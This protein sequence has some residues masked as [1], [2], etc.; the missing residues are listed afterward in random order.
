MRARRQLQLDQWDI[1]RKL[2]TLLLGP[3]IPVCP[4]FPLLRDQILCLGLSGRAAQSQGCCPDATRHARAL[5]P[6]KAGLFLNHLDLGAKA[7]GAKFG[8]QFIQEAHFES[9][10]MFY[11]WL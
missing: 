8:P 4:S 10:S 2:S 6:R 1:G 9:L 5:A 11:E 3:Q 7:R